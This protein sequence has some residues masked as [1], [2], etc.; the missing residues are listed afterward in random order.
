MHKSDKPD[1][2][3]NFF[4]VER[5]ACQYDGDIDLLAVHADAATGGDGNLTH[6]TESFKNKAL[7]EAKGTPLSDLMAEGS[8]RW[9]NRCTKA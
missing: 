5:L 1:A 8:P 9:Q 2:F 4:E 3:V 7:G 6:Q